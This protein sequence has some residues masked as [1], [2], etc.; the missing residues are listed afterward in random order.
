[1]REYSGPAGQRPDMATAPAVEDGSEAPL[2]RP[3]GIGTN[4]IGAEV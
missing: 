3:A 2:P 1:M 4:C